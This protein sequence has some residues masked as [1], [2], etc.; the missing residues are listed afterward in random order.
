MSRIGKLP[1]T[2]PSG[3]TVTKTDAILTVKGPKAELTKEFKDNVTITIEGSEIVLTIPDNADLF[4]KSLWGTYA[5]HIRNMIH[6]V[7]NGFERK[8]ILEGVGYKAAVNGNKFDFAL[9]FSHPV[10]VEIPSTLSATV[11]KNVITITGSDKEVVGQFA[12]YIRS[13]KKPEPYKGKGMRYD[14]E[15]IRRKEGKKNV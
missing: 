12:A 11:E 10:S 6:G 8:L 13:L 9:G 2:I 7:T 3:V 4:T 15:V 5:A 14:N 1:I